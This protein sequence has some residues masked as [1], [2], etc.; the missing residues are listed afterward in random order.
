MRSLCDRWAS[1]ASS[2]PRC[3]SLCLQVKDELVGWMILLT[4]SVDLHTQQL[5]AILHYCHYSTYSNSNIPHHHTGIPQACSFHRINNININNIF[6]YFT[7][8]NNTRVMPRHSL[9]TPQK[10]LALQI[11]LSRRC[12]Y[13]DKALWTSNSA[14][15]CTITSRFK[16]KILKKYHSSAQQCFTKFWRNDALRERSMQAGYTNFAISTNNGYMWETIEVRAIYYWMVIGNPMHSI[17]PWHFWW[18]WV[19]FGGHFSYQLTAVTRYSVSAADRRSVIVI[20]K[21]LDFE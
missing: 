13:A 5:G 11:K 18:S 20:A 6:F 19:T 3:P 10:T 15:E 9:S 7:G 4:S 2:G 21:F 16:T 17:K 14:P 12:F 8:N 1:W